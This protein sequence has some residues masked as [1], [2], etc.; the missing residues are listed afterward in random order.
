MVWALP[1][2]LMSEINDLILKADKFQHTPNAILCPNQHGK[3][4]PKL[5]AHRSGAVLMCVERGCDFARSLD[6]QTVT[7]QG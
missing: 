7:A 5:W 2:G 4:T 3:E 1:K 6:H